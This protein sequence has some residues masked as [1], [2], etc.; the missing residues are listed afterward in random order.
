MILLIAMLVAGAAATHGGEARPD[1]E[2]VVDLRGTW[3]FRL[4]DPGT[5]QREGRDD[6]WDRI[7]VPSPWENEGYAG[8][9]GFAWYRKAFKLP[10]T[11]SGKALLLN[12][13]KIDDA[14]EVYLNGHFLG[15]T[16]TMPPKVATAYD[17]VR[18]YR[19]PNEFLDFRRENIIEVRVFDTHLEG[20]IVE[21][22]VGIYQ[23]DTVEA[24]SIDLTGSWHFAAG[25][26][27]NWR[28]PDWDDAE[29]ASLTVPAYWEPQGY[30]DYDGYA[31]YRK[32]FY[33]PKDASES[34]YQLVLGKV[35][36]LDE[37]FVNGV[38]VGRTGAI[39]DARVDGHE[40]QMV[41]R[42]GSLSRSCGRRPGAGREDA[43]GALYRVAE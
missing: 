5:T 2:R 39:D 8:Y 3:D 43:I 16:G 14:D 32:T 21:G 23:M 18:L 9:D 35:D 29:W 7:F 38:L 26:N 34:N 12:L 27:P 20:G 28:S 40:W 25:D 30:R 42:Y 11:L 1:P 6:T 37:T 10:E 36:D 4:G 41:R 15:S 17:Q 24:W 13:G 22:P 19:I 33:L 31:W